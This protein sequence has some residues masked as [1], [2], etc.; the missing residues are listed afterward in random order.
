MNKITLFV[1]LIMGVLTYQS[2][3]Q[4]VTKVDESRYLIQPKDN[5]QLP[6]IST[7]AALDDSIRWHHTMISKMNAE[8]DG[9]YAITNAIIDQ[10]V[11][12]PKLQTVDQIK[13]TGVKE[14]MGAVDNL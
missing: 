13:K 7:S 11:N 4:T 8:L 12:T 5:T 6:Y 3:A 2:L 1:I 9:L 14:V 10:A